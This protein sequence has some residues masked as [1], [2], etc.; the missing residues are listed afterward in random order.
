MMRAGSETTPN[1]VAWRDVEAR[2]FEHLSVEG[3]QRSLLVHPPAEEV[4]LAIVRTTLNEDCPVALDHR[5]HPNSPRDVWPRRFRI[6][7]IARHRAG[8]SPRKRRP[9]EAGRPKV[10]LRG[11]GATPQYT[12]DSP[13]IEVLRW[14]LQAAVGESA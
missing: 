6:A 5:D 12:P 9:A 10:K 13:S 4:P 3:L 7:V 8:V 2:F 1:S 11:R 14:E